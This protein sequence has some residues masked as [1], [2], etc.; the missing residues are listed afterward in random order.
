MTI[1]TVFHK[2]HAYTLTTYPYGFTILL[3]NIPVCIRFSQE[4]WFLKFKK[5]WSHYLTTKKH[6]KTLYLSTNRISLETQLIHMNKSTLHISCHADRLKKHT[7]KSLNY[8]IKRIIGRW[9]FED[10]VFLVHASAVINQHN[11]ALLFTGPQGAG[12]STIIK[13]L[14][15]FVPIAD[16]VIFLSVINNTL[17]CF[18]TPFTEKRTYTTKAS[19]LPVAG[20]FSLHKNQNLSIDKLS[21]Q[22]ALRKTFQLFYILHIRGETLLPQILSAGNKLVPHIPWY[23]LHFPNT[24]E[25]REFFM[26]SAFR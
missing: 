2:K 26:T 25:T 21:A 17:V 11:K 13:L 6:H 3:A 9:L 8:G 15:N 4:D 22:N 24:I 19:C 18:T 20:I 23:S 16:D 5:K 7:F 1:M 14:T 10:G 12:K